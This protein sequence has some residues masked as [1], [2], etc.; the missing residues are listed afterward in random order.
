VY[1]NQASDCVESGAGGGGM[2]QNRRWRWVAVAIVCGLGLVLAQ[3]AAAKSLNKLIPDLY[4]GNGIT[5]DND[6]HN[7]HFPDKTLQTKF[8][9]LSNDISAAINLVTPGA[10]VASFTFDLQDAV[11]VQSTESLGPTI[12][13]RPQT[14]GQG[15]INFGVTYTRS[16]FKKFDGDDLS[17]I[18]FK[19]D[20]TPCGPFDPALLP[21]FPFDCDEGNGELLNDDPSFE[22][23][24]VIVKLDVELNQDLFQF[25]GNYGITDRWDVGLVVPLVHNDMKVKASGQ[26]D[27]NR[28]VDP[29]F[30]N[31]HAFCGEGPTFEDVNPS[32]DVTE[33]APRDCVE[34]SDA[35]NDY[36]S[37]SKI[38]LGD[39]VLR[40]KYHVLRAG[41]WT[42]DIGV[43]GFVSFASGDEDDFMGTGHTEF[44]LFATIAKTFWIFTP[45][46]NA[47]VE[48]STG[49][50]ELDSFRYIAGIEAAVH[51][52]LSLS[53]D[54]VGRTA[55]DRDGFGDDIVDF[56]IGAK[57]NPFSTI[58]LV[59]TVILPLN[60]DEG[61]RTDVTWSAGVEYTF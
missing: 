60:K 55:L 35:A 59:G 31:F 11:F 47:G 16:E 29:A 49:G 14:I 4:G 12:A 50:S 26:V 46:A 51:K 1:R 41:D 57:V 43:F 44:D 6:A 24:Q 10:S 2:L 39:I 37:E 19:L 7:A 36:A 45:H 54:V 56:A 34:G 8:D 58:A 27:I 48:L 13:E 20:H 3:A 33:L 30:G 17:D 32:P 38:G 28:V 25:F 21:G 61:L 9:D 42:P 5:L 18:E 23:D 15:K 22:S 52:R 53:G 40:S